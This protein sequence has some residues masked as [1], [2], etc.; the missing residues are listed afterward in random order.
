[1][2]CTT[3]GCSAEQTLQ[4]AGAKAGTCMGCEVCEEGKYRIDCATDVRGSCDE[5]LPGMYKEWGLLADAADNNWAT[6]CVDCPAA[7]FSDFPGSAECAACENGRYE[8]TP[9]SAECKLCQPG[10]CRGSETGTAGREGGGGSAQ[11]QTAEQRFGP[12]VWPR[13]AGAGQYNA[14]DTGVSAC[15]DCAMGTFEDQVGSTACSDCAM[16]QYEDIAG[17]TACTAC[18]PGSRL[19]R[20]GAR[21]TPLAF[22]LCA[23]STAILLPPIPPHSTHHPHTHARTN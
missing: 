8:D 19:W 21:G 12:L 10:P 17:R 22:H 3:E 6:M 16:G 7:H 1:M 5:C 2:T 18:E 13:N 14:L 11:H 20:E 4:E 15:T 9:K 23:P